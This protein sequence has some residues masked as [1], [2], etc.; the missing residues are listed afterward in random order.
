MLAR[1][2]RG[3][4]LLECSSTNG[5]AVSGGTARALNGYIESE[6]AKW[7]K[8]VRDDGIKID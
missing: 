1:Y 2:I 4:K 3:P 6:A 8:V 7:S 5:I